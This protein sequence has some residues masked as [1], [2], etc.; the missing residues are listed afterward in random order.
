MGELIMTTLNDISLAFDDIIDT[1]A[2]RKRQ[3]E[4]A[5]QAMRERYSQSRLPFSLLGGGIAGSIPQTTENIRRALVG[6]GGTGFQ[7]SGE[8]MG[9]QLQ[10][11][12]PAD[13][14]H[15][16]EILRKVSQS[17]PAGAAA[18]QAAW[19]EQ[20]M[21]LK[22]SQNRFPVDTQRYANGT[23]WTQTSNGG[24][25]VKGPDNVLI[26]GT[27]AIQ[28][29]IEAGRQSDIDDARAKAAATAEGQMSV[30]QIEETTNAVNMALSQARQNDEF[31]RLIEQEGANGTLWATYTPEFLRNNATIEFN[32]LARQAGLDVI[33][34]VTF[35]ALS[36]AELELAMDTAVPR[37][38][39]N[40][41]ALNYFRRRKEAQMALAEELAGY[42]TY[43][44]A[45]PGKFTHKYE[46]EK[47]WA[48]QRKSV[49]DDR[50]EQRAAAD[51]A[52]R[53]EVPEEAANPGQGS[54]SGN[55][56]ANNELYQEY[57]A[58]KA[59]N[60]GLTYAEFSIGADN[61]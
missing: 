19:A 55:A 31:I 21:T 12:N 25:I 22:A 46:Y 60:P 8:V 52:L 48:E 40:A 45:N 4:A 30:E 53:G 57:L 36:K 6:M 5:G 47:D 15:R 1:P 42:L 39:T 38:T 33:A 7:T 2:K 24:I 41:A 13:P 18:L 56:G 50:A 27:E 43:Q 54:G 37:F 32:Q 20:D 44:R 11:L 35:G 9:Q 29:A 14:Q 59:Q 28:N 10:G 51:A 34:S 16:D 23:T 26:T 49:Y 17:N 3:V 61:G 58:A